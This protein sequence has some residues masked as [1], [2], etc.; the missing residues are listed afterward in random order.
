M[1]FTGSIGRHLM[2]CYCAVC[3]N[4]VEQTKQFC[5]VCG[6]TPFD[7]AWLLSDPHG[8]WLDGGRYKLVE[9]IGAGGFGITAKAYQYIDETVL[10]PVA[11]KFPLV[12]DADR[13]KAFQAEAIAL[14]KVRHPNL[15]TLHDFFIDEGRPY[16]VMEYVAGNSL[17]D[18]FS[19]TQ[20]LTFERL[21]HVMAQLGS[22]VNDLH[23]KGVIHCDLKSDNIRLLPWLDVSYRYDFAKILDFGIAALWRNKRWESSTAG[24]TIG[25]A[26]P[27]QLRGEPVPQSD[28]FS[29]GIILYILL[30]GTM[31][32]P[33]D[34]YWKSNDACTLQNPRLL[35]SFPEEVI[36]LVLASIAPE[37]EKR[38]GL[39]GFL[40]KC[41][42]LRTLHESKHSDAKSTPAR[43]LQGSVERE[44]L[45]ALAKENF[46]DAGL[47]PNNTLKAQKYRRAKELFE[48]A[49]KLGPLPSGLRRKAEL[50]TKYAEQYGKKKGIWTLFG[51]RA[52]K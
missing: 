5:T 31:P 43:Q 9:P 25:F 52:D 51:S 48:Q 28:V 11:V 26:A 2:P 27:E 36:S 49:E 23:D 34:T 40:R 15:V 42:Y 37:P 18:A 10:G 30:T 41:I 32:Y 8:R 12:M 14:R 44:S 4:K 39:P 21:F 29:L 19:D 6:H 1:G 13:N 45:L 16:L 17:F 47:A 33:L 22:A 24:G 46:L 50:A 7:G 20:M 3:W 35:D 38:I